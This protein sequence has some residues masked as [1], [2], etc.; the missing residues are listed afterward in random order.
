MFWTE[1]DTSQIEID[2]KRKIS[3]KGKPFRFQIPRGFS[4][5]GLNQYNSIVLNIE[6]LDFISWF[7]DL[8]K[9]LCKEESFESNVTSDDTLRIKVVEGFTQLFDKD[10]QYCSETSLKNCDVDCM[11]EISSVYGPF[12]GKYGLVCKVYQAR[13]LTRGCLFHSFSD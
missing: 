5:Y 11:M 12:N 9:L 3:Y 2:D 7:K 8:E 13:I 10:Y 6:Y 1:I 4:E